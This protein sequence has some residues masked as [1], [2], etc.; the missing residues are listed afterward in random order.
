MSIN[1]Q[2]LNS[3]IGK[4]NHLL[5]RLELTN[6]Q[7]NQQEL[8]SDSFALRWCTTQ[9]IIPINWKCNISGKDLLHIDRQAK[10]LLT[11]TQQFVENFP[12]NNALLWGSRG[13]G[14]S[15]LIQAVLG[16]FEPDQ[17]RIIEIS[18]NDFVDWPNIVSWINKNSSQKFILFCD[19]LSFDNNDSSYKH[20]KAALDGSFMSLPD[21]ALIYATSN[22][23]HLVPEKLA[24]NLD[25]TH[26]NGE[27][28]HSEAVEEAISLSD[29]FGLWLSFHSLTQAQ[30]LDIVK[31][32][33]EEFGI[34]IPETTYREG[35]LRWALQRGS[36]SGRIANQFARDYSGKVMLEQKE[37]KNTL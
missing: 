24:D 21:N 34:E 32:W 19:D 23:R 1:S 9:G 6:S 13:T 17:L 33:L 20:F 2:L 7:P 4:A 16:T 11:N 5:D 30:Y 10:L 27:V 36:R 14:K 22:R 35:A 29:R 18:Y 37:L 8:D 3:V 12:A 26:S 28:H 31:H 25:A 15:S